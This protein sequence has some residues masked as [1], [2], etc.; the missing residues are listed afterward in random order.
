[1]PRIN[2]SI[3]QELYDQLEKAAKKSNITVNYV[4]NEALEE[5]YG[6]NTSYDYT[7][8]I[9]NMISEARKMDKDFTLADLPTFSYVADVISDYKIKE[10]PA[11]VRARLGKMFNESVRKGTAKGIKRA[12]VE[13]DGKEEPKFI[14]RAAV[15][16]NTG[17]K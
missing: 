5:K 6:K 11:A 16:V 12:T 3:S 8:A 17:K 9:S 4:I 14:N 1:M 15:Y 2:L 13:R 10:S 7:Q